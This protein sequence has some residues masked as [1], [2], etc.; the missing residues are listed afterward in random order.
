MPPEAVNW[1]ASVVGTVGGGFTLGKLAVF[2]KRLFTKHRERRGDAGDEESG[3]NGIE[4]EE[5]DLGEDT[6]EWGLRV[7]REMGV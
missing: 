6:D 4:L 1:I 5:V 2:Q 7:R 3:A